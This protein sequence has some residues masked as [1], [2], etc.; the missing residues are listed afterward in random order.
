MSRRLT[1]LLLAGALTGWLLAAC[2]DGDGEPAA[3]GTTVEV[4][5]TDTTVEPDRTSVPAGPV[6]FAAE[7]AGTTEHELV[8][9]RTELAADELPV[10]GAKVDEDAVG[11]EEIGEIEEFA[12]GETES[13]TFDLAAGP[14]VLFCNVPGH[15]AAGMRSP[16]TV[17]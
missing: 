1:L 13:A 8:V 3:E 17:E 5:L 16:F 4:K 9:L 15:Y 12:A 2:G 6:T 14:Y 7:N 11:V 10:T